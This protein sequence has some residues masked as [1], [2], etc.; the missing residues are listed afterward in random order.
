MPLE[1]KR[2]PWKEH[3]KE[4]DKNVNRSTS[5]QLPERRSG[6]VL[7]SCAENDIRKIINSSIYVEKGRPKEIL[8]RT[9]LKAGK[10]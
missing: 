1:D 3:K 7:G 2:N 4:Q 8:K 9:F 10:L 5:Q 6:H